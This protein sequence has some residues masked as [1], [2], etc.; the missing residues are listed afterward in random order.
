MTLKLTKWL[1]LL[2]AASTLSARANDWYRWR[3]P[4][5]NGV[6]S[7]TN[8]PSKWSPVGDPATN[9]VYFFGCQCNFLCLDGNDG[10]VIWKRQMTEEFG[11]ISTFGGRTPSPAIDEDQVFIAGIS[12]G[13]G[14]NAR[15]QHR[16]FA[17]NKKTG[18]LNWSAPTGGVPV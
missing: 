6:S 7:E 2:T 4:E 13:W 14:E 16:I 1:L 12:F 18:E 5:Q 17:L 11:T 10:H 9:R 3:G 8:I 15:G